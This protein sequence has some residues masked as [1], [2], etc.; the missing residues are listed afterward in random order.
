[1][2]RTHI[3]LII[4]LVALAALLAACGGSNTGSA[5]DNTSAPQVEATQPA[6]VDVI[7]TNA[8]S[9]ENGADAEHNDGDEHAADTA[10]AEHND[11]DEHAADGD[12]A[13]DIDGEHEHAEV[14]ADYADK[15]NPFKDDA[16]AIAAGAEVYTTYCESCHGPEGKGDGPAADALD[17][18]P[19]NFV[20]GGMIHDLTDA[21]VFW[22][23]SEGGMMEPFNS[24][25]PAWKQGLTEEQ[26]WQVI[27]YLH[28]LAP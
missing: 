8:E 23:V 21:Y 12:S 22:R 27:S 11:G 2:K 9:T 13:M 20:D 15:V 19:A 1:M 28:T 16:A 14:P 4:S 7:E 10:D 26:R 17:P 25:M 3:L 6:A 5:K 18:K 24:T